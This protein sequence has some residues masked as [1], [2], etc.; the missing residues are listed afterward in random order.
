MRFYHTES[1]VDRFQFHFF[2]PAN[3]IV[4]FYVCA[5]PSVRKHSFGQSMLKGV[6]VYVLQQ[7]HKIK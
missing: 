3:G 2:R 6:A 4:T 1:H 5:V 7:Q